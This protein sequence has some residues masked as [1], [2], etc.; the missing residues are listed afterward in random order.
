MGG[1]KDKISALFPS[2]TSAAIGH[3]HLSN[4][5][6]LN[7]CSSLHSTAGV[8]LSTAGYAVYRLTQSWCLP[9]WHFLTRSWEASFQKSTPRSN[10]RQ[11]HQASCLSDRAAWL[12]FAI[13]QMCIL[14]SSGYGEKNEKQ[15]TECSEKDFLKIAC[16]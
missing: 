9:S 16:L 10:E 5:C 12:P 1:E 8:P 13:L 14:Q 11:R 2:L 15:I 7:H 3:S 4:I 6:Q